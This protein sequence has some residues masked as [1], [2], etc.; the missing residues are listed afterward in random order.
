MT[1]YYA[2]AYHKHCKIGLSHISSFFSSYRVLDFHYKYLQITYKLTTHYGYH[3]LRKT[4]GKFLISYS[5]LIYKFGEIS[6]QE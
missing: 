4:F 1:K 2:C 3:K 6:F 5:E